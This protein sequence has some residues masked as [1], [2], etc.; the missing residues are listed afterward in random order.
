MPKVVMEK[1]KKIRRN[2]SLSPKAVENLS[3]MAKILHTSQSQLL[4]D[5]IMSASESVFK[6]FEQT[7]YRGVYSSVLKVI[8]DH[9]ESLSDEFDNLKGGKDE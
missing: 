1:D 7:K 4:E 3:K 8:A 9:L 6:L 5:M 2:F